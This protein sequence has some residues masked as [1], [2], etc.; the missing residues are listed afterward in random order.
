MKILF[1]LATLALAGCAAHTPNSDA[2]L[3]TAR[4]GHILPGGGGYSGP[5]VGPGSTACDINAYAFA[6]GATPYIGN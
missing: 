6:T 4:T 3:Q 2:S 1:L 5:Y